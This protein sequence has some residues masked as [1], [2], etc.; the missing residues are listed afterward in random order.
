LLQEI[1]RLQFARVEPLLLEAARE[2]ART[3]LERPEVIEWFTSRGIPERRKEGL[4]WIQ[5]MSADDVRVAA[6]DLLVMNRVIATWSPKAKQTA[7]NVEELAKDGGDAPATTASRLSLSAGVALPI[8]PFPPHTHENPTMSL[9]ERLS[10]GVFLVASNTN[11]VF[12]SGGA[13]TRYEREPGPDILKTLQAYQTD[14][15]LVLATPDSIEGARQFWSSFKGTGGS[16][17]VPK[18]NV[19]TGD[20]PALI[21]I[22]TLMDRKVIE[23]GWWRDVELKISAGEGSTL[24]IAATPEKRALIL[25]WIK[26]MVVVMPAE[27]EIIW[28]REVAGHNL[29]KLQADL[30]ALTWERDPQGMVQ[31]LQTVSVGHVQD[32]ARIYF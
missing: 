24:V 4:A 16:A 13:L 32:V 8:I 6:R 27:A 23:A 29:A 28:A 15:I 25:D 20:L 14:R 11:G 9:P 21:I 17:G 19:S 5:G 1:Q 7:V 10:S 30:Q 26:Q 22:K 31:D 3:Y 2:D 18:G 12:V